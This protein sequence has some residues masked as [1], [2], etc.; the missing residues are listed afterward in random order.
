MPQLIKNIE[1]ISVD[2]L[3]TD[4][5]LVK[6]ISG[7]IQQ[8]DYVNMNSFVAFLQNLSKTEE[9]HA[10]SK[11]LLYGLKNT[12]SLQIKNINIDY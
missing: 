8:E 11:P 12:R 4:I 5:T 10:L 3:S 1:A 6:N 2:I 9:T 7:E